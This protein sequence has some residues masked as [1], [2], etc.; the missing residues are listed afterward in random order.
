MGDAAGGGGT[1]PPVQKSGGDVPSSFVFGA[2]AKVIFVWRHCYLCD[3]CVLKYRVA[4]SPMV[5]SGFTHHTSRAG[6]FFSKSKFRKWRSVKI[7]IFRRRIRIWYLF[8]HS[9]SFNRGVSFENPIFPKW[10]ILPKYRQHLK[11]YNS[12]GKSGKA[13]EGPQIPLTTVCCDFKWT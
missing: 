6:R 11:N 7:C 2:C 10:V 8:W 12:L 5:G 13:P 9:N 1:R 4:P 3:V